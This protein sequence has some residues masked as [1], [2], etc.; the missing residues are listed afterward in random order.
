M[1]ISVPCEFWQWKALEIILI[2]RLMHI[3]YTLRTPMYDGMALQ[4]MWPMVQSFQKIAR[5]CN[6]EGTH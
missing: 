1:P 3:L 2:E 4:G 6:E 5:V